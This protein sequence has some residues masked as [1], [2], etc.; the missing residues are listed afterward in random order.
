MGG[1]EGNGQEEKRN[2][3]GSEMKRN[4]KE[5]KNKAKQKHSCSPM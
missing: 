1:R 2:I 4:G 3:G 5:A